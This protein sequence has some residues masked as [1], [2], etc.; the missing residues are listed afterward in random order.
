MSLG[1]GTQNKNITRSTLLIFP[2]NMTSEK[3]V[4]IIN[5]RV[6]CLGKGL[7]SAAGDSTD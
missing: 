7:V 2:I 1:V 6:P 5:H 4:G 3:H